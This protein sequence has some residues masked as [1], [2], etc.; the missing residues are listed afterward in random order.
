MII[1]L[2]VYLGLGILSD[3][4]I[5]VYTISVG[6][7]WRLA[8]SLIS[9]PIACLNFWIIDKLLIATLSWYGVLAYAIGNAL[10]C[11]IIM[12]INKYLKKIVDKS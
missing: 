10:G 5:T 6:K 4:L 3:L 1:N 7:D 9:I 8:A 2:L 11:F 12:T